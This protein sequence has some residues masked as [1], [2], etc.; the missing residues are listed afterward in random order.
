MDELLEKKEAPERDIRQALIYFQ[1]GFQKG[2][3]SLHEV[4]AAMNEFEPL[5]RQLV[6]SHKTEFQLPD[7]LGLTPAQIAA[8]RKAH[9]DHMQEVVLHYRKNIWQALKII[10]GLIG[11]QNYNS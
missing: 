4:Y 11:R 3:L 10:A 5:L 1:T 9:L 2:G 7:K 8:I 6:R